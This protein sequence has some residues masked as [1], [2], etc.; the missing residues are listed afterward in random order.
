MCA[1]GS[2]GTIL[3][4]GSVLLPF[5]LEYRPRTWFRA[6]GSTSLGL[7]GNQQSEDGSA[8]AKAESPLWQVGGLTWLPGTSTIRTSKRIY[9]PICGP[10]GQRIDLEGLKGR[11]YRQGKGMRGEEG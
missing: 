7:P 10:A 8:L 9:G 5:I 11:W 3:A 4:R 1:S 2:P 6:S